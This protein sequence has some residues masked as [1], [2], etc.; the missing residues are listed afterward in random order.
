M[1]Y[2]YEFRRISG[3]AFMPEW[4]ANRA[5]CSAFSKARKEYGKAP[6]ST[7]KIWPN[8]QINRVNSLLKR[9]W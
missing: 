3:M 8:G 5:A 2:A 6:Y 9:G 4:A 7:E 1:K